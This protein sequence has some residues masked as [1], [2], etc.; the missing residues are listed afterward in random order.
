MNYLPCTPSLH[1]KEGH[2][3]SVFIGE[4]LERR[5]SLQLWGEL[6]SMFCDPELPL[7]V[8]MEEDGTGLEHLWRRMVIPR[9]QGRRVQGS[10]F[11]S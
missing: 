6:D 1:W 9:P 11:A 2:L 8:W 7:L 3:A 4:S 5:R 10:T